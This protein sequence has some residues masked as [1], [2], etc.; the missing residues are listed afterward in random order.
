MAKQ[1]T[2]EIAQKVVRKLKAKKAASAGKGKAHTH[3]DVFGADGEIILS[4]S[5]RH[6]SQKNLGHDHLM[7]D[8][9]TNAHNVKRLANCTY[10][11][12]KYLEYLKELGTI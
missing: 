12:K 3:Y 1:I 9:Y 7:G 5:V 10:S 4:F 6:G 11:R 2:R 8:L